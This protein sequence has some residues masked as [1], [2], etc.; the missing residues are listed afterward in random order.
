MDE[1]YKAPDA[2]VSSDANDHVL[3]ITTVAKWQKALIYT[4]LVYLVVFISQMVLQRLTED[5]FSNAVVYVMALIGIANLFLFVA[6][7]VFN[8]LLC[9]QVYG[10]FSRFIMI[11]ISVVPLINL[12]VIL[13]ASSRA[14][15]IIKNAGFKVGFLG[16]KLNQAD[17][18]TNQ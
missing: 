12:F 1:L 17:K 4:F 11:M 13:A 18:Q 16:A 2:Q 8:G 6:L 14:S 10:K 3:F 15:K 5:T 7:V 9:W